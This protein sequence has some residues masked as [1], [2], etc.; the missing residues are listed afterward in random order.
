MTDSRIHAPTDS[1]I[2]RAAE[3]LAGGELIGMPTETVY[4]LAANAWNERAVARIFEVKQRPPSNPLIVH[5]PTVERLMEVSGELTTTQQ[6]Q[7]GAL[8]DLW[9]G[10]FTVVLPKSDR[11]PSIVSAGRA[12]VAVRIPRHPVALRLLEACRFP[13]AAPSANPS[14]YVSPTTAYHVAQSLPQG[15]PMILDG[16]ECQYGLESTIVNLCETPARLLRPGS[17]TAE[18][19]ASRLNMSV[20]ELCRASS[21]TSATLIA[22]GMMREHYAPRTPLR[23]I[24]ELDEALLPQRIGR[25][26]FHP[27]QP[28]EVSKYAHV[29]LLSQSGSLD[30]VATQ[31]FAALRRL[32]EQNFDMIVVDRCEPTHLGRAVMDRLQRARAASNSKTPPSP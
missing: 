27:L 24:D 22:P 12:T 10:P 7:L 23:F 16:G 29:E 2:Q 4:G 15:V 31:L 20:D 14:K 3:L 13:L 5:L 11:I 21:E 1:A 6:E 25:L 28:N 17:I 18:T 32:D 19:I 9:P 8:Q 26:A 30:D